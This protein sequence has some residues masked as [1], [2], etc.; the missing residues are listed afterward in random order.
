METLP[1]TYDVL[2]GRRRAVHA[3]GIAIVGVGGIA[4]LLAGR[5]FGLLLL[6]QALLLGQQLRVRT[7]LDAT[8]ARICHGFRTRHIPWTAVTE[9]PEPGRWEPG[10][11]VR[12]AGGD[13]VELTN[14]P[15]SEAGSVRE[16]V[17]RARHGAGPDGVE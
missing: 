15:A 17:R 3:I 8:G 11:L 16:L 13:R 1:R 4:S 12:T 9:V 7:V 5:W 2:S 10:V 6:L 14:V